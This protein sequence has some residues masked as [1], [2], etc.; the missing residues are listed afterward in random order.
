VDIT[1]GPNT[2]ADIG[3]GVVL[4]AAPFN[5]HVVRLLV[6]TPQPD[7]TVLRSVVIDNRPEGPRVTAR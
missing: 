2:R 3:S 7:R 4:D 5:E 1:Q 6:E